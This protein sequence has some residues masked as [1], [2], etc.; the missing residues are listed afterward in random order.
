MLSTQQRIPSS[1][2]LGTRNKTLVSARSWHNYGT[3]PV[4]IQIFSV[5]FQGKNRKELTSGEQAATHRPV[6]NSHGTKVAWI[7]LE[8]DGHESDRFVDFCCDSSTMLSIVD[9]SEDV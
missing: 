8:Q 9:I 4:T 2:R 5:D 7:E 1:Q 3:Y 6:F